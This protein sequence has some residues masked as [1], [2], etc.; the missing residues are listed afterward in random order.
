MLASEL[1]MDGYV[2]GRGART[3]NDPKLSDRGVRR[4]TCM[5][6][7]KAAVESGAVTHGAVRGMKEEEGIVCGRTTGKE[8][9]WRRV[10]SNEK[11]RTRHQSRRHPE[12]LPGAR[13]APGEPF[14]NPGPD[15]RSTLAEPGRRPRE[16]R[17]LRGGAG[18]PLRTRAA[19]HARPR[20][21]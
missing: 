14:P 9:P 18:R 12:P 5:A 2:L 16:G 6:G 15:G 3:P 1:V 11:I 8:W 7:G 19:R 20:A 10:H 13:Q 17:G 4:G 21:D